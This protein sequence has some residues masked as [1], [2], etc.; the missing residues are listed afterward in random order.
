VPSSLDQQLFLFFNAERGL[1]LLDLVLAVLSSFDFWLPFLIGA[2]LLV[3]WRGGFRGR[4]MLVC[5]LVSVAIMEAGLV[6]PLKSAIGRARPN[7][8]LPE[9]RSIGLA[10]VTPRLLALA[11]PA[12]IKPAR[13]DQPPRPG[14]SLP[15]G[16]TANMFCF[17]T[18]LAV[19]YGWRGALF[20]LPA[21]LV[22]LSRVATGSHWPSDVLLSAAFSI[23]AT[24][25]LLLLYDWLWR[26]LVPRVA[27][28]FAAA[29]PQLI[30]RA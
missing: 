7:N 11:H 21:T 19:F 20:F 24:L 4:A 27:P 5:L 26:R 28:A 25:G 15:S 12:R 18:V 2:G 17:G 30:P 9:A 13:V 16:H 29:H 23:V 8:V 22:G 3:L 10:A 1:P 6:N 14:K